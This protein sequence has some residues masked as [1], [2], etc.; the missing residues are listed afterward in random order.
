MLNRNQPEAHPGSLALEKFVAKDDAGPV[1]APD[2]AEI[3]A[4]AASLSAHPRW[5]PGRAAAVVL[6]YGLTF[7]ALLSGQ[8]KCAF[9]MATRHPCPGCGTPRAARALLH[10][11]LA[12]A[13]RYTPMGPVVIAALFVV[14]VESV[15][16]VAR[17]GNIQDLGTRGPARFAVRVLLVALVLQIVVWIARFFGFFGGPVPVE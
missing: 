14:A 15:F 10:G 4:P 6:G 7:L 17:Y 3:P 9:A 16:R 11:D 13:F 1:R 5:Y 12:Q 2:L 8:L